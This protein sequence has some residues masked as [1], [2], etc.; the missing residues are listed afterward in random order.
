MV[1]FMNDLDSDFLAVIG[2]TTKV[3]CRNTVTDNGGSDTIK[4]K[5]FL[6]SRKEVY[7][8]NEV[9]SVDEGEPYPY[10]SDYSDY[11]SPN[12]G[13]DSNRVK[14]RNGSAQ[15]WW[16]RT[17]HSG[18]GSDVRVVNTA[19]GLNNNN[20]NNSVGVPPACNVI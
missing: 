19:G 18:Y 10:Y 12:T 11:T 4:D 2:K 17:P 6:L 20:A 8:G 3:T 16:L 14:Y 13:A 15:W 1:G 7:M 9:S 5:F